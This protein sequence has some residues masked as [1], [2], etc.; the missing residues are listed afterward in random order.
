MKKISFPEIN[1]PIQGIEDVKLP[2]MVR[3][4]QIYG[5]DRI[6]DIPAHLRSEFEKSGLSESVRGKSIAL[7]V[8]SR[9]STSPLGFR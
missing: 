5:N 3:I 8:G 7:T 9:G 1:F 4:R 2:K 6:T